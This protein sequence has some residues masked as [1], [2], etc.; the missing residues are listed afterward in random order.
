MEAGRIWTEDVK[1]SNQLH[2][3]LRGTFHIQIITAS[4]SGRNPMVKNKETMSRLQY[5]QDHRGY[6]GVSCG[7]PEVE[8]ICYKREEE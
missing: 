6:N 4:Y 1:C 8:T 7:R 2:I 3:I 5:S